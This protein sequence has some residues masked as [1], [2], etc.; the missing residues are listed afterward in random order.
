[1]PKNEDGEFELVV[2]NRQLLSIVFILMVLFGVVFSMGYFLGRANTGGQAAADA[3]QQAGQAGRPDATGA[4]VPHTQED[5]PLQP[6]EAKV[7]TPDAGTGSTTPVSTAPA[8]S[9]STPPADS[10]APAPAASEKTKPV[11]AAAVRPPEPAP[12]T[13]PAPVAAPPAA[14]PAAGSPAAGQT[15]LQVAA[16]KKPQAQMLLDLLKAKGF[17]A[18]MVQVDGQEVYRT[19]VGPVKD[20]GDLARTKAGLEGA[21]FKPFVKK[22]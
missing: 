19:L 2:G 7:A 22:Y 14:T 3:T 20:A 16:V 21:G 8:A 6:G 11:A 5:T 1:M 10:V 9:E 17:H 12:R 13:A 4:L 18:M 15:F